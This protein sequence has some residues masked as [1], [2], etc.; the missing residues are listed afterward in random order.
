[1]AMSIYSNIRELKEKAPLIEAQGKVAKLDCNNHGN[2]SVGFSADGKSLVREASNFAAR[3]DCGSMAVGQAVSVWY[4]SAEPRYVSFVPPDQ[5]SSALKNELETIA[6][7]AY[8][9]LVLFLFATR[10]FSRK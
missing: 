4:S 2:Y 6:F 1:M 5:V 7:V 9:L 8:P 3:R 10:R